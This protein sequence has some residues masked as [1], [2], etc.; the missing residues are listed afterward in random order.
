MTMS[1]APREAS[2]SANSLL[3]S[4]R[5]LASQ[6]NARAP[7]SLTSPSRSPVVRA[8]TA[9][10][11]FSLASARARE[12]LSP[13]PTPTMSAVLNLTF[14]MVSSG[15]CPKIRDETTTAG[16]AMARFLIVLGLVIL[17]VGLLWPYLSKLGLGRLPG[18]IVIERENTTF[19]FPLVTCLLLS[20]VLSLVLWVASR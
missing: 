14:V 10:L 15:S 3:T 17:G 20:V 19:Y 18:D 4:P 2:T 8:A 5:L 11:M 12:A 16:R 9:T 1:G 6:A 13:E 7:T